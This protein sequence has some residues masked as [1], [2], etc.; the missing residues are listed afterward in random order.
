MSEFSEVEH[1]KMIAFVCCLLFYCYIRFQKRLQST[2]KIANKKQMHHDPKSDPW[3]TQLSHTGTGSDEAGIVGLSTTFRH[4][5]L[6]L[7]RIEP[8]VA[9][10][11]S[12]WYKEC[13][14]AL[15]F[16]G[17][18]WGDW[19]DQSCWNNGRHQQYDWRLHLELL[20]K[21]QFVGQW[22]KLLLTFAHDI[23]CFKFHFPGWD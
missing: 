5:I 13:P 16:G 21:L 2:P 1:L 12:K 7:S 4:K 3:S 14:I 10:S 15:I 19:S 23:F 8:W 17:T 6:W 20:L 22:D 11:G 9:T 18:D